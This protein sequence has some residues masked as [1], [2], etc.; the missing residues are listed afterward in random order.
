VGIRRQATAVY[1]R[2]EAVELLFGEAAFEVGAGVDARCG[3]ALEVHLVAELAVVLAAEEMVEAHLVERGGR[4]ERRQVATDAFA[5]RVG[6]GHHHR[7]VPADEGADAPLDELVAR[8]PRLGVARD[9][10]DVGRRHGRREANLHLTGA[11][12]QLHQQEA[13]AVL[14]GGVEDG[15]EAVDPLLGLGGIG[16]GQ[17]VAVPVEYH[18]IHRRRPTHG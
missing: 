8:E 9:G 11:L 18:A 17:L 2:A 14:A 3:V 1:F 12:E 5:A 15:V 7:G 16:V 6:P 13:G 4:R 10:V